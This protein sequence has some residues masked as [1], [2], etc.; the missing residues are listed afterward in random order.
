[1]SSAS[2]RS[3][4]LYSIV[5][6]VLGYVGVS[7]V[8]Q[9]QQRLI[10]LSQA[11]QAMA[12]VIVASPGTAG[13][14]ALGEIELDS[15]GGESRRPL[16]VA[17]V[18][19]SNPEFDDEI[20]ETDV[21]T[22]VRVRR[23]GGGQWGV[24]GLEIP[25][26]AATL[27]R[28]YTGNL[29]RLRDVGA[30]VGIFDSGD[31]DPSELYVDIEQRTLGTEVMVPGVGLGFR[32]MQ[33]VWVCVIATFG[34]LVILRDRVQHV[35][36]DEELAVSERWLVIDGK[37]GIEYVL[38]QLW[39][40]ALILAPTALSSGLI[41]GVT[42]QIAADGA[43]SSLASDAL[44]AAGV[45]ILLAGNCWLALNTTSRI[46]ELRVKRLALAAP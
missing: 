27:N 13:F 36:S 22:D 26:D 37:E 14:P 9:H 35:L 44:R 4:R 42:A 7:F 31:R 20:A 16:A 12:W 10:T 11:R 32:G 30:Q 15:G 41:V 45:L 40:A 17:A 21:V 8:W 3:A 43:T 24:V 39:L 2:L 1:M 38:S 29:D 18:I 19:A 5:I 33:V 25:Q 46:L 28:I 6:L 34:F 23:R